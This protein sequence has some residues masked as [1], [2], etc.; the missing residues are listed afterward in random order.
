[1]F[2]LNSWTDWGMFQQAVAARYQR[3]PGSGPSEGNSGE[4]C[5]WGGSAERSQRERRESLDPKTFPAGSRH[6]RVDLHPPRVCPTHSVYQNQTTPCK[7]SALRIAFLLFSTRPWDNEACL[8][9]FEKD[10]VIQTQEKIH[11]R[12][13]GLSY[14]HTWTRQHKVKLQIHFDLKWSIVKRLTLGS[15]FQQASHEVNKWIDNN[16]CP[17]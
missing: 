16:R 1:M 10:G 6:L 7:R 8:V 4:V 14:S 17:E 9:Q 11:R 2:I 3:H 5:P 13:N 15:S 12:H